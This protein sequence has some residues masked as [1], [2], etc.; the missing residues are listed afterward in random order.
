EGGGGGLGTGFG[1]GTG[2]AKAGVWNLHA[3]G[4]EFVYVVDFSGSITAAVDDLK[5][6]LKRSV[7]SLAPTQSFNVIIFFSEPQQN[8][9]KFIN[10]SFA[11]ALVAGDS[12]NKRKFFQWLDRKTPHGRTEPVP[13]MKRALAFKPDAVFFFSDGYF[14]EKYVDEMTKANEGKKTS[15]NCLL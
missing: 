12:D 9:D 2:I 10:E 15:I 3:S 8:S 4:R 1:A 6:E 11:P 5:R 13:A 7:G 14:D